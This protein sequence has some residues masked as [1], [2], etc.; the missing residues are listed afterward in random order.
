MLHKWMHGYILI[1]QFS[2]DELKDRFIGWKINCITSDY[3]I[4]LSGVSIKR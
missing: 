3:K 4:D 1:N 2:Y